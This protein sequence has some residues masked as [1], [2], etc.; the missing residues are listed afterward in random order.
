MELI[1]VNIVITCITLLFNVVT[2][3]IKAVKRS[4]C[5]G[6]SCVMKE[7]IKE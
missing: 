5:C 6:S 2:L 7:N 3:Y 1:I 4:K